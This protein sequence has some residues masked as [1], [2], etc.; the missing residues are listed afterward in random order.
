MATPDV[1]LYLRP[2]TRALVA[3]APPGAPL[4]AALTD[5]TIQMQVSGQQWQSQAAAR[6]SLA[7]GQDLVVNADGS[8]GATAHIATPEEQVVTTQRAAIQ[9]FVNNPT[10]SADVKDAAVRAIIRHLKLDA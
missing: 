10:P 2:V 9:A 6:Q 1:V 3:V 7:A 5:N 4:P 8:T